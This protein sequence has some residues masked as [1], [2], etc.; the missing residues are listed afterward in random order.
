MTINHHLFKYLP[1]MEH[2]AAH[3]R[4]IQRLLHYTT[5]KLFNEYHYRLP[6]LNINGPYY[7]WV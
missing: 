6:K 2:P 1:L 3:A 4:P 7:L 5:Q